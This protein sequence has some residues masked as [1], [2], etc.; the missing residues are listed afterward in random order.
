MSLVATPACSILLNLIV[1][2]NGSRTMSHQSG[3]ALRLCDQA[4]PTDDKAA[5]ESVDPAHDERLRYQH[6]HVALHH[7]HHAL[8]GRRIRHGVRG[9]LSLPLRFLQEGAVLVRG[10]EIVL[11]G[12][13]RGGRDGVGVG[14]QVD[15]AEEG[16][17]FADGGELLFLGRRLHEDCC[18]VAE[19]AG[20][21]LKDVSIRLP[22]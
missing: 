12:L 6:R 17:L 3:P 19:D 11:A 9:R 10:D 4:G 15:A 13:E 5:E 7:A 21:D 8:H 18:V 22:A 2:G 14:A 20:Q 1:N 16:A